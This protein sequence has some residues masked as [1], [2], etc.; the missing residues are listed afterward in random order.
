MSTL[1][2]NVDRNFASLGTFVTQLAEVTYRAL[3]A[4]RQPGS[5]E[6]SVPRLTAMN[7]V[8]DPTST[9]VRMLPSGTPI[10]ST[11]PPAPVVAA[12]SSSAAAPFTPRVINSTSTSA[13]SASAASVD[14]EVP[15]DCVFLE[16]VV[17]SD[18]RFSSLVAVLD[19]DDLAESEMER[20]D[21]GENEGDEEDGEEGRSNAGGTGDDLYSPPGANQ[22]QSPAHPPIRVTRRQLSITKTREEKQRAMVEQPSEEPISVRIA[23]TVFFIFS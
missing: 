21:E 7:N 14:M 17:N 18:D 10:P 22:T 4:M 3:N 15:D 2:V 16:P 8:V 23:S 19:M 6:L 5:T 11:A 20:G 12:S 1:S 13:A 9:S